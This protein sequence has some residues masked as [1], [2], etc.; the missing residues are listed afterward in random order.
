MCVMC[1]LLTVFKATTLVQTISISQLEL[2]KWPFCFCLC[3]LPQCCLNKAT[4]VFSFI[5]I[6]LWLFVSLRVKSCK[7]LG[8]VRPCMP[9]S[10]LSSSFLPSCQGALLYHTGF[11]AVTQRCSQASFQLCTCCLI[12][13]TLFCT[14]ISS[15]IQIFAQIY[16]L[17]EAFPDYVFKNQSLS[18]S[19]FL[20]SLLSFFIVENMPSNILCILAVYILFIECLHCGRWNAQ[21]NWF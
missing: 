7:V 3:S 1:P 2:C 4:R 14:M 20:Y 5:K 11:I 12:R 19:H 8:S 15:P 13:N 17:N 6:L 21:Y 10:S 16:F 18:T 9:V